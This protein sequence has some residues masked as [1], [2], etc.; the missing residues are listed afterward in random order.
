MLLLAD[1]VSCDASFEAEISSHMER[2]KFF[3][4]EAAGESRSR[5][6]G[7][8]FLQTID[9]KSSAG[10]EVPCREPVGVSGVLSA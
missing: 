1:G 6:I 4:A 2:L 5:R 10:L 8:G 9:E 7:A 3:A